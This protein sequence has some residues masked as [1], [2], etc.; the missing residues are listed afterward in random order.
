MICRP[1]ATTHQEAKQDEYEKVLQDTSHDDEVVIYWKHTGLETVP[2][3]EFREIDK[4][5]ALDET[6]G[7]L[8]GEKIGFSSRT[9]G[10]IDIRRRGENDW[11]V[12]VPIFEGDE[13]TGYIY[14]AETGT[15]QILD[16][17]DLFFEKSAWFGMLDFKMTRY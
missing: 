15:R 2:A 5:K 11:R 9:R 7:L 10:A 4:Q 16:V 8:D 14:R 12:D 3:L 1:P 13:W 17:I 6:R